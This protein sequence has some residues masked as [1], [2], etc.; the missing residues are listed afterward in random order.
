MTWRT[1]SSLK[2]LIAKHSRLLGE[3]GLLRRE[4]AELDAQ[5]IAHR[6][7]WERAER[8][9]LATEASLG[10]HEVQV[11]VGDITVVRPHV[12]RPCF[13]PGDLTRNLYAALKLAGDWLT[14]CPNLNQQFFVSADF[15][16]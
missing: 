6:Q 16:L 2:W 5:M 15:G 7:R 1:P 8:S 9:L 12:N 14:T 10:M 13:R 11:D 3:I 4:A